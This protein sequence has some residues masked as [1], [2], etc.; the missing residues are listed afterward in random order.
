[1][2]NKDYTINLEGADLSGAI[3]RGTILEGIKI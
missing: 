2:T 1:M 3:L